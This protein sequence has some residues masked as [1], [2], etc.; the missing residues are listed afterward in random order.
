MTMSSLVS[1][2]FAVVCAHVSYFLC[3]VIMWTIIVTFAGG[4]CIDFVV[5][6]DGNDGM[7]PYY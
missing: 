5:G 1:I 7:K 4:R 2:L 6:I 3:F